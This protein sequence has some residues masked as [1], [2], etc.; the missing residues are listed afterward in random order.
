M[1]F[2][3]YTLGIFKLYFISGIYV[4]TIFFGKFQTI[5]FNL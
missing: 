1:Q 2:F 3:P 5:F 4:P